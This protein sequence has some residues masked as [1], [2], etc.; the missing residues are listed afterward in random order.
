M[1]ADLFHVIAHR[2]PSHRG[3]RGPSRLLQPLRP[4][5]P[6]STA[7]PFL[8]NAK[9]A[10]CRRS[11]PHRAWQLAASATNSPAP[12]GVHGTR[13]TPHDFRTDLRH[14]PGQQRPAHPH[15]RRPA[16][17]S[18]PPDHPGTSPS[19]TRTSSATTSISPTRRRT[20][21]PG[22]VPRPPPDEWTEFEEHFD[23]RK[24]E[25]GS[26]AR[27]YGT[28]ATTSTPASAAR[29]CR[30][31][32]RCCPPRRIEEDLLPA[33]NKRT[34]SW[35]GEIEGLDLTLTFCAPNRPRPPA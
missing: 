12:P 35:L 16:R 14:R 32:P 23:K 6:V 34:E 11:H 1:S 27:P 9:W 10:P 3:R 21:R 31:T 7:L 33:G 2:P 17:T 5:D 18:Q 25:L 30:S 28:R 24:V 15:R 19:S 13:F 8:F 4:L 29:C 26:C 22:R 20:L